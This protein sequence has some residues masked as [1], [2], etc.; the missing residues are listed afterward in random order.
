MANDGRWLDYY[1]RGFT[2]WDSRK[3]CS[4]LQA[5]L[6][7][8]RR[9]AQSARKNMSSGRGAVLS[10]AANEE[11]E[12][13]F[14][15]AAGPG[16]SIENMLRDMDDALAK[17]EQK[18]DASSSKVSQLEGRIQVACRTMAGSA[19]DK[20]CTD[21]P[22]SLEACAQH[23]N[24]VADREARVFDDFMADVHESIRNMYSAQIRE[25]L[26]AAQTQLVEVL[27]IR[28]NEMLERDRCVYAHTHT[29]TH[30]HAH[31]H[32]HTHAAQ[33]GECGMGSAHNS[34]P[35]T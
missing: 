25:R 21:R 23:A 7:L 35:K 17:L 28:Y 30:T 4:Q 22:P 2:P 29:H 10:A 26:A 33:Q 14:P 31:A 24:E 20:L 5:G 18:Q 27:A 34:Y 9:A 8:K 3:P 1:R 11:G 15:S 19:F 16:P 32:A 13:P 12:P 6:D